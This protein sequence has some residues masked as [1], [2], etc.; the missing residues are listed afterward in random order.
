[1]AIRYDGPSKTRIGW[2]VQ[3]DYETAQKAV[4]DFE[5]SIANASVKIG[6]L[7]VDPAFV[8]HTL[9]MMGKAIGFEGFRILAEGQRELAKARPDWKIEFVSDK[10]MREGGNPMGMMKNT[11]A[12]LM[13]TASEAT[14]EATAQE[15][16]RG[17]QLRVVPL[18]G[19][20]DN[21]L[22][23]LKALPGPKDDKE[24]N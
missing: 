8:G 10:V 1:M 14:G 9:T 11:L 21:I 22:D 17:A 5:A 16:P 15:L 2:S 13:D 23:F 18:D 20:P 3:L 24:V 12:E 7:G 6:N 4:T 19:K